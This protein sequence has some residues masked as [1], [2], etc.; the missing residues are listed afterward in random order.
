M[1]NSPMQSHHP[2]R[3]AFRILAAIAVLAAP[4]APAAGQDAL[5]LGG[6][7]AR[8]LAHAGA[9]QALS[10]KGFRPDLV[11]GS[12]MG[13]IIGALHASG[14]GTDSIWQIARGMDW[15]ELFSYSRFRA[16]PD[17]EAARP[18]LNLGFRVD[19]RRYA[20]GLMTDRRVNRLLVR[21]LFD[22]GARAHGDF[23][24]LPIRY[25]A[26][27]GDLK[28]G[29]AVSIGSGD[30]ALAVRA[31]MAVP[32]LFAPV[33]DEQG[34]YLVDGGIAD[35]LPVQAAREAGARRVVAIDVIDP[36]P[37]RMG[38]LNPMQVAL[39][40]FRLTLRNARPRG[41]PADVVIEPDIDPDLSA[42]VFLRNARPLLEAGRRAVDEQFPDSVPWQDSGTPMRTPAP[43]PARFADLRV[44]TNDPGLAPLVQRAFERLRGAPYDAGAVLAAMD[45][46]YATGFF[47]GIWPRVEEDGA[48]V[49][50]ADA[51]PPLLTSFSAG[52]DD[53]LGPRVLGGV[54]ARGRATEYALAGRLGSVQSWMSLSARHPLPFLPT[55]ATSAG[56]ELRNTDIRQF[57]GERVF[58]ETGVRR[59]GG[60]AGL[61]WTGTDDRAEV[62]AALRAD[63]IDAEF[64]NDGSAW[65]FSLRL[66]AREPNARVVGT[67][68]VVEAERRWGDVA[69]SAIRARG[70]V[71]FEAGRLRTALRADFA[72]IG[73]DA[74]LD[75][76][77][78]LGQPDGMPGLRAGSRRA[79]ARAIAGLDLAYPIPG[80]GHLRL[81]FR[82][83][84]AAGHFDELDTVRWLPGVGVDL[85]WWTPWGR[86]ALGVGATRHAGWR[87]SID[88]GP[89]F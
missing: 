78:A 14:L 10:A 85:L 54:R 34:R 25:R 87:A 23:D 59:A 30:L 63:R 13:S 20:E 76:F 57:D 81:R 29:E 27:A 73:S 36:P 9:L 88:L 70:S 35:Y 71:G 84:G 61:V 62:V 6:G 38:R 31:S 83:G 37:D 3:L 21:L 40:S 2:K 64:G 22:A 4:T 19:R 80:E 55:L 45:R 39:R 50:R 47:T 24:R 60:W 67:P 42:A 58:D 77:P 51:Q 69:W 65:G 49:V 1:Q 52:Y 89:R 11:V 66:A 82:A 75:E 43:A 33:I 44:E 46:L 26:V 41:P 72:A 56:L 68:L 32:G 74:T 48:L 15:Q 5:V 28:T 16:L 53:D 79:P 7:G 12:S 86:L 8:G 18:F 17:G